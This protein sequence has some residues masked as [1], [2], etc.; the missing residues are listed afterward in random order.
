MTM[1]AVPTVK[2][3]PHGLLILQELHRFQLKQVIS[4]LDKC[5]KKNNQCEGCPVS[6]MCSRIYDQAIETHGNL[7]CQGKSKWT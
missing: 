7:V 2:N 5:A 4:E 6:E 1:T 3:V